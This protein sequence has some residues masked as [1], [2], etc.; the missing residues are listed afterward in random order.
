MLKE[1]ALLN[2]TPEVHVS[3]PST[4]TGGI[5]APPPQPL[6]EMPMAPACGVVIRTKLDNPRKALR[7]CPTLSESPYSLIVVTIISPWPASRPPLPPGAQPSLAAPSAW[8]ALCQANSSL[9]SEMQLK[10]FC[11][12]CSSSRKPFLLPTCDFSVL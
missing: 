8:Y 1:V 9:S 12:H 7:H 4:R 10:L 2:Q 6:K 11:R 3:G 5:Q